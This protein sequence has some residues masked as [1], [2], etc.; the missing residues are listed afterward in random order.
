MTAALRAPPPHACSVN[1]RR[2]ISLNGACNAALGRRAASRGLQRVSV[3]EQ[4]EEQISGSN[5]QKSGLPATTPPATTPCAPRR[6]PL[7]HACTLPLPPTTPPCLLHAALRALCALSGWAGGAFGRG[8][9]PH[10]R[11]D[12]RSHN[13]AKTLRGVGH[14]R[15]DMLSRHKQT[16]FRTDDAWRI[17]CVRCFRLPLQHRLLNDL[18]LLRLHRP[19]KGGGA[20][21]HWRY[22]GGTLRDVTGRLYSRDGRCTLLA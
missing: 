6:R 19:L 3:R 4:A 16:A 15:S 1:K 11:Q 20:V 12:G 9:T 18:R 14:L 21:W 10:R 13:A 17:I 8:T 5:R 22:V 7:P 2:S